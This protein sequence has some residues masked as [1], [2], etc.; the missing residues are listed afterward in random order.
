MSLSQIFFYSSLSFIFGI[1]FYSFFKFF[2]PLFFFILF[3]ISFFPCFFNK[4]FLVFPLFILFFF[5]GVLKTKSSFS[6]I[7]NNLAKEFFGKEI[8]LIG[9]VV[10]EPKET[11]GLVKFIFLPKEKD[12]GKIL[13]LTQKYQNLDFGTKLEI[14]GILEEPKNYQNFDYKNYLAKDSIYSIIYFPKIKKI[15]QKRSFMFYLFSFKKRIKQSLNSFLSPPYSALME[16]LI[17]GEEEKL[18]QEWKEKFNKIGVRHITAVS[19]MNITLINIFIFNFL[20]FVGFWRKQAFL[21]ST[22]FIVFYILMIG[23]PSSAVR[24]AIM[25]FLFLVAQIFGRLSL[26]SRSFVFALSLMLFLNPLLLKYDVGFQL[27]FLA[28]AG[29]IYLKP[30]FDDFLKKIPQAFYLR[31]NLSATLG[32][33]IFTLPILIQNFNQIPLISP[34][35]NI[36]ILP[37]LPFLTILGFFASF[38]GIF[39]YRLGYFLSLISFPFLFF[40]FKII[41]FFSKIP[42]SFTLSLKFPTFFFI[43]FYFLLAIFIKKIGE[44]RK[45]K[46]LGIMF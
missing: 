16:S 18:S 3:L 7:E 24:A 14:E 13:V 6:K 44:K 34:L 17:F 15:N 26:P 25:S 8:K 2:S 38:S 41:D 35:P 10:N 23:L 4:K 22:L 32:A 33:Q 37:F 27:S 11:D 20:L 45:L 5:F 12:F 9:E 30:I 21:I 42:F 39:F 43:F 28:T 31:E 1:F 19:G 29:L 46:F 40:I 36:L